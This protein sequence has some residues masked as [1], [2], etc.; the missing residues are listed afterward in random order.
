MAIVAVKIKIMPESLET[1]LIKIEKDIRSLLK[2]NNVKKPQFE[3]QPVAFGLKSLIVLLG[4]PEEKEFEKMEKK[5]QQ[6]SGV[7]SI[8]IIDMRRAI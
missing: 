2:K 8:E 6:I 4:W 5:L 1:N 7:S 3:V